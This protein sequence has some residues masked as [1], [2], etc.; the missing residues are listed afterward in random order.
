MTVKLDHILLGMPDLDAGSAL[1]AEAAGVQPVTGGSHPGFG[2]RNRLVS[3]GAD[4]FLELI[5]PDP[6]QE[7]AGKARAEAIAALA[8]P[9]LLTFAI[10]TTAM[11][12]TRADAQAAGLTASE[13]V[14]MR[15]TRPDGVTLEWTVCHFA[16][17]GY[18]DVIPFA[19]D[20]QG[21]PHPAT[22][23]PGGCTIRSFS[24]LHPRP[25]ALRDIYR[26][27][28]I[29]IP[30]QAGLRGGFVLVLDTPNGALC[31]TG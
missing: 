27:I 26:A 6:A 7:I 29:D 9:G 15:R 31:L 18:E 8:A 21:S 30:V 12:E 24:V 3:L 16:R 1:F 23:T 25:R 20:W 14:P 17:P 28:G 2:T 19:I 5:A 13:L 10:Q 4:V 11:S 22:T